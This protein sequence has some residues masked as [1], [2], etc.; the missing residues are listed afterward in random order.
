M[1][2]EH[3]S[4]EQNNNKKTKTHTHTHTH[5][6]PAGF[7]FVLFFFSCKRSLL[8]FFVQTR[9]ESGQITKGM[10]L[11]ARATT[12]Q[13]G[14]S[15]QLHQHRNTRRVRKVASKVCEM[16]LLRKTSDCF[17]HPQ[18][19]TQ[20]Y[21]LFCS[22]QTAQG[23]NW[24]CIQVVFGKMKLEAGDVLHFTKPRVDADLCEAGN[25]WET[26]PHF[27]VWVWFWSF[28]GRCWQQDRQ[29]V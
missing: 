4:V 3:S 12:T 11:S 15:R 13:S 20:K 27:V 10:S 17:Q 22:N 26:D 18:K 29:R 5:T 23:R 8:C 9:T 16:E 14:P 25:D 7:H 28:C 21:R 19:R 2:P 6:T 1:A 24:C